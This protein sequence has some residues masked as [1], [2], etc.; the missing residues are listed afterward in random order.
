MERRI[1]GI[2]TVDTAININSSFGNIAT[3]LFA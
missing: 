2:Y 3:T 1:S